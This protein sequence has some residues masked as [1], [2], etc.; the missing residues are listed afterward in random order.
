M[1]PQGVDSQPVFDITVQ[2]LVKR[3]GSADCNHHRRRC[4]VQSE[5]QSTQQCAAVFLID[6]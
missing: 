3:P 5:H 2:S 4:V 6:Q 1:K